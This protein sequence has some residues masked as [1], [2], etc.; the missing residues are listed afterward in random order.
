[1]YCANDPVNRVDP[2]GKLDG[3]TGGLEL[4]ADFALNAFKAFGA[5]SG[6]LII[7]A[8][9]ASAQQMAIYSVFMA[10]QK[11]K[12]LGDNRTE[13]KEYYRW[14][15]SYGLTDDQISDLHQAGVTSRNGWTGEEIKEAMRELAESLKGEESGGG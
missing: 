14:G 10:N 5:L 12:P 2:S 9:Y 11:H 1:M 8:G 7:I 4:E 6:I 15:R 3:I 13:N